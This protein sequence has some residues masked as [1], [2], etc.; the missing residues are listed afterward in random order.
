[1]I[2]SDILRY[3]ILASAHLISSLADEELKKVKAVILFGSAAQGRA[4]ASSDIDFFFD[5][6]A[7]KT[8]QK[9]LRIKLSKEVEE[10]YLTSDA[11][12]FKLKGVDNSINLIAGKLEDWPDLKRSIA[13]TGLVMYGKYPSQIREKSKTLFSI[14]KIGRLESSLL[15][16]LYGYKVK[17][18]KYPGLIKK[19]SGIRLGRTF[20][21]PSEQKLSIMEIFKKYNVSYSAYDIWV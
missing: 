21:V 13:S 18:K 9:N 10:F 20:M 17:H 4:I 16:K 2:A 14:E 15:N 5:T 8:F 11:L 7:P 3:S 19:I 1:M 12:K 6:D